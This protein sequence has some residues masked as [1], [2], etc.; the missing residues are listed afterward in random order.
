MAGGVGCGCGEWVCMGC[1]GVWSGRVGVGVWVCG[2]R[3]AARLAVRFE[4]MVRYEF[5]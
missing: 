3:V 4:I 5:F 2:M 1:V